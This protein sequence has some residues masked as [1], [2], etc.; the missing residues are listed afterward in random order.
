M[1]NFQIRFLE[2][3]CN[4]QKKELLSENKS[5]GPIKHRLTNIGIL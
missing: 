5:E 4:K 3:I 1:D 2:N